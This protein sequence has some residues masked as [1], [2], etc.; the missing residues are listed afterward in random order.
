MVVLGAGGHSLEV[1][2]VLQ[3]SGL[4]Q[5][6]YFYDDV[7]PESVLFRGYPVLKSEIEL[8]KIYPNEFD[9]C[10][11]IGNPIG[12]KKLFDKFTSIGGNL[13]SIVSKSAV[14]PQGLSVKNYD[15]MPL[16]YLGPE[17]NIGF[18]TL[19]NSGSQIHHEVTIGQFAEISPRALLLGKVKIGDF[20]SLGGNCTILPKVVLGNN[21]IVGAGSV[22][23]KNMPDNVTV[24]GV[25][26]KI[27]DKID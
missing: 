24:L 8:K 21:V 11:G 15:I 5:N 2:D 6:L 23:T 19:L 18:G 14:I 7:N 22:V 25:P 9:F 27:V 13:V 12:R 10:I 16:C 4:A 26:A 3:Q 1:L 20:C 17:T